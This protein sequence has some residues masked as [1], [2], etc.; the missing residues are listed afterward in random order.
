M[1]ITFTQR[2]KPEK[3]PAALKWH[4]GKELSD[5]RGA[6]SEEGRKKKIIPGHKKL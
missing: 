2:R 4:R 6:T 1:V 3:I 5:H